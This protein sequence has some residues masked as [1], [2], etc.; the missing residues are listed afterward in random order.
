M[1]FFFEKNFGEVLD[2][3]Q[4]PIGRNF[5]YLEKNGVFK[6][7]KSLPVHLITKFTVRVMSDFHGIFEAETVFSILFFYFSVTQHMTK[8]TEG[9]KSILENVYP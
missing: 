4:L 8:K 6:F 9:D 3:F 7:F 1:E 5:E 2:L